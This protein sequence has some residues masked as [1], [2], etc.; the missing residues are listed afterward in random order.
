MATARALEKMTNAQLVEEFNKLGP[1]KKLKQWKGK[2][3]DLI[4][5]ITAGKK[6]ANG[7]RK[8]TKTTKDGKR[9]TV[10]EVA[11][12]FL[13]DDKYS[14]EQVVEEVKKEI[15]DCNVTVRSLASVACYLRRDGIEIPHRTARAQ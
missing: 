12:R 13:V 9:I 10:K 5:K 4:A 8:I 15:P 6:Q 3:A 7:G 11:A 2:K 14:Y 1:A